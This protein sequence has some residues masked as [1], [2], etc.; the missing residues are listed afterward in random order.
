[1]LGQYVTQ[2]PIGLLGGANKLSYSGGNS[3]N[4]IDPLGLDFRDKATKGGEVGY[5]I[6]DAKGT[7]DNGSKRACII[8]QIINRKK[9]RDELMGK[10]ASHQPLSDW[11]SAALSYLDQQVRRDA[12]TAG[13]IGFE[14]GSEIYT[15]IAAS[16][17]SIVSIAKD[18][19]LGIMGE[20]TSAQ[21]SQPRLDERPGRGP[22][23]V[24]TT[25]EC[26]DD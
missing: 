25:K 7:Y 20:K 23:C 13:Q 17:R 21:A 9:A 16:Q 24:A 22:W 18:M 11:D 19:L 4:R 6:F 1:M 15:S 2:D 10:L 12:I 14:Y 26:E 8:R 5:E 3:L